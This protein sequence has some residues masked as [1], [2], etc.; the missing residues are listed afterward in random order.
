MEEYEEVRRVG[1][2]SEGSVYLV[3]HLR[4]DALFVIKKIFSKN[5]SPLTANEVRILAQLHHPNVVRY[6]HSFLDARREHLCIVQEYCSGGTLEERIREARLGETYFGEG[7]VLGWVCEIALGVQYMHSKHVLHRDLKTANVLLTATGRVKIADFGIS[8]QLLNTADVK[9]TCVGSPFYMSPEVCEDKPYGFKSDM[10]ALGCIV[11][12]LCALSSAFG[13]AN[14]MQTVKNIVHAHYPP[15]HERYSSG[16]RR[17]VSALL[18][19]N[20]ELRWSAAQLLADPL[21]R[22]TL[23]RAVLTARASSEPQDN[24]VQPALIAQPPTPLLPTTSTPSHA[25]LKRASIPRGSLSSTRSEALCETVECAQPLALSSP[26]FSDEGG[27]PD[28][29]ATAFEFGAAAE[30]PDTPFDT[31]QP[32]AELFHSSASIASVRLE[33]KLSGR[34]LA[35]RAPGLTKAG[36][37]LGLRQRKPDH[38]PDGQPEP[39]PDL[40]PDRQPNPD[41]RLQPSRLASRLSGQR[42]TGGLRRWASSSSASVSAHISLNKELSVSGI[43]S[44]ILPPAAVRKT[45]ASPLATRSPSMTYIAPADPIR[46]VPTVSS[47]LP[48]L[49]AATVSTSPHRRASLT[50]SSPRLRLPAFLES[51]P[52]DAS[53]SKA[54]QATKGPLKRSHSRA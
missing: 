11:Y 25:T 1:K 32:L 52:S 12:E 8:A 27:D 30:E 43:G 15:I 7:Q 26:V 13:G 37:D 3:R 31:D 54:L 36:A 34:I 47:A 10:W 22:E 16:M 35:A 9:H 48:L 39:E 29:R 23:K 45:S 20:T 2:G 28:T 40:E 6:Y 33:R 21:I 49:H 53:S 51:L 24:T 4:S 38:E 50:P 5:A 17:I 19:P 46:V 42:A 41:Q 14:L 18:Q 44:R